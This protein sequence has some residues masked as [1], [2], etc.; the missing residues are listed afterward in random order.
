MFFVYLFLLS[1]IGKLTSLGDDAARKGA[2]TAA[3]YAAGSDDDSLMGNSARVVG[4]ITLAAASIA[5]ELDREFDVLHTLRAVNE[6]A[7]ESLVERVPA[8][9]E[10]RAQIASSTDDSERPLRLLGGLAEDENT[11]HA[12]YDASQF[13]CDAT[14][15]RLV[16]PAAPAATS[17]PGRPTPGLVNKF[18][19]QGPRKRGSLGN[20]TCIKKWPHN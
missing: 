16:T 6:V 13:V 19:F 7:L 11:D 1:F 5:Q 17:C 2:A 12:M 14:G 18:D 20:D 3:A 8:L 9:R 10:A 15:C 4:N